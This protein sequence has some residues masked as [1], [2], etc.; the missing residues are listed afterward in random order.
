VTVPL[1][2][3]RF[4]RRAFLAGAAASLALPRRVL[5]ATRNPDVVIVGAGSA[6]IFAARELARRGL[7][8]VLLEAKDRVGGRAFTDGT[9]FGQPFDHGCSW[10]HQADRNPYKPLAED[11]GFTLM[12][13]VGDEEVFVG[14][15]LANDAENAAYSTAWGSAIQELGKAGAKGLDEPASAAITRRLDWTQVAENW[16]GAMSFGA[17]FADFSTADWWGIAEEEPNY[18]IKEGFG[19]LVARAAE[20]IPVS[21]ATPASAIDWRGK[22]VAVET[23][24]GRIEAKAAIV[25]VAI[26]A[27]KAERIRFE[28]ALPEP[29]LA[30]LDGLEMGLLGKI[31]LGFE[32]GARFDLAANDWVSYFTT[33]NEAAYFLAWPFDFDIAIGFCGGKFGWDLTRAG[34]AAAV[35][36]GLGEFVKMVGSDARRRFRTGRYTQWGADPEMLGAYAHERPGHHGAR[37]ALFPPVGERI[38]FAGEALAGSYSMTCGGAAKSGTSVASRV[39]AA[40]AG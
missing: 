23:P 29:V 4:G 40:L 33:S 17:D 20:G 15:R 6:G 32:P 39:A 36:F 24:A 21:L 11:W 5:G 12:H 14:D 25:T 35:D 18:M 7:S 38:W 30:G 1:P 27:L 9:S 8:F 31:A 26:G 16:I 37:A 3:R 13:H 22:G 10:L 2:V 28:P 19:T 34:E